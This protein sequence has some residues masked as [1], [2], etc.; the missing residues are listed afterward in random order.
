MRYCAQGA[1]SENKIQRWKG[2]RKEGRSKISGMSLE[3]ERGYGKGGEDENSGD[4]ENNEKTMRA[5]QN[6]H[7]GFLLL[8]ICSMKL[9]GFN[10]F[11]VHPFRPKVYAYQ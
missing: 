10:E 11:G 2:S 8:H 3:Q 9:N 1:G 6:Q 7:V 4:N 5:S